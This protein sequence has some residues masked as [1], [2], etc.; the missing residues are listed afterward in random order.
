M[1]S[2]GVDMANKEVILAE[3]ETLRP[4][5]HQMIDERLDAMKNAILS[6]ESVSSVERTYPLNFSPHIFKGEKPVA[7]L[8]GEERVE[9]NSWIKVY[10]EILHRCKDE[11]YDILMELRGKISGRDR[12]ILSKESTGMKRPVKLAEGLFAESFYDTDTLIYVLTKRILD[13]VGFDYR[14]ISVVLKPNP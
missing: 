4:Q 6:G 13:P 3:I 12:L 5:L 11:K 14:E 8:F 7:V 2:E 9:R 1:K 10:T